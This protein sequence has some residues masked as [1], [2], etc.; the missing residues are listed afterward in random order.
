M[1]AFF[2]RHALVGMI[3]NFV[4]FRLVTA[5]Y[6]DLLSEAELTKLPQVKRASEGRVV[7]SVAVPNTSFRDPEVKLFPGES[8]MT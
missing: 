2:E 8:S 4:T 3:F 5:C 1:S 7:D 6:L